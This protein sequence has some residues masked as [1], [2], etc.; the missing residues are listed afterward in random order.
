MNFN[1]F[2][3]L[4]FIFLISCSEEEKGENSTVTINVDL[5]N[6]PLSPTGKLFYF[7]SDLS[8]TVLDVKEATNGGRITLSTGK[9]I[10]TVNLTQCRLSKTD[11]QE[12]YTLSTFLNIPTNKGD[13]ISAS[14]AYPTPVGTAVITINN[15]SGSGY[16]SFSSGSDRYPNLGGSLKSLTQEGSTIQAEVNLFTSDSRVIINSNNGVDQLYFELQNI[17]ANGQVS[18]DYNNFLP[19][20]N[21]IDL[22]TQSINNASIVGLQENKIDGHYL[23]SRTNALSIPYAG[24]ITGYTNYLTSFS[25]PSVLYQKLGSIPS[26]SPNLAKPTLSVSSQDINNFQFTLS[27]QYTYRMSVWGYSDNSTP[28]NNSFFWYVHGDTGEQKL[29]LPAELVEQYPFLQMDKLKYSSSRF[30]KCIEGSYIDYVSQFFSGERKN[31]E[32][33]QYSYA[34]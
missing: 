20:A 15:Y 5:T 22:S 19:Y 18:V 24:Y 16:I 11:I 13:I 27:E 34:P 10:E 2:F 23:F 1:K 9:I 31:F 17:Q 12:N 29:I 8:G 3:I 25:I 32:L 4:I 21:K 6:S 14:L 30:T 26:S 33:I 7:I 28:Y